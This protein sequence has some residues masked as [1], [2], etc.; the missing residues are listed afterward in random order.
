MQLISKLILVGCKL[1]IFILLSADTS[2][3]Q[4]RESKKL[5]MPEFIAHRGASW[6]A[7]ENTMASIQLAWEMQVDAVEFDVFITADNEIVVF[8]DS[9]LNRITGVDELIEEKTLEELKKL[10]YG[11]WKSD[12][13]KGE[14]ITTL[15]EALEVTPRG[16]RVFVDVKS[17]T[18]IVKPMLEIFDDSG[19][20]MH[21]IVV[22]AFS[23]D[24]AAKTKKMRPHVTVLQLQ[25]FRIDEET[26]TWSPAIESVIDQAVKDN[27]DGIN[28]RFRGPAKD[29]KAIKKVREAGLGYY[30][31]TVNDLEDAI[32][33]TKL[34]VDGITTDRPV[35][36]KKNLLSHFGWRLLPNP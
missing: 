1:C 23:R 31:W 6:L 5:A 7:P 25:S 29:P 36:M 21:Q 2:L 4:V 14:S 9:N 11:Q 3:G 22:I 16:A 20:H 32:K 13:W 17:G 35:W 19:I 8:H 28:V 10:D 27:L 30:I 18:E 24:V 12:T 34:G 33:A 26:D 15:R